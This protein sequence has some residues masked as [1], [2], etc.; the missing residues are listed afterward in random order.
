M[1]SEF[2]GPKS[3]PSAQQKKIVLLRDIQGK[4]WRD[5]APKIRNVSGEAPSRQHV[6]NTYQAFGK[7]NKTQRGGGYHR[8]GRRPWKLTKD[9]RSFVVKRLLVLRKTCVCTAVTLQRELARAKG[10][11]VDA[12]KIRK[13]LRASGFQWLPRAQKPK[14]SA[15]VM[16]RRV[17]FAE[18][19]LAMRPRQLRVR[20][21]MAMD[22]VVFGIPPADATDRENHCRVGDTHMWRKRGEGASPTLAG[23]SLYGK[24]LPACRAIGLWGGVSA[25]GFRIVLMHD[26]KKV[27]ADQWAHA[28]TGGQLSDALAAINPSRPHGPWTVLS[29]NES[30]LTAPVC[31]AAH[32]TSKVSLWKIP[33]KSPD[34][35]PVEKFWGWA[36]KKLRELDL[37]DLTAG[38]PVLGRTAY[39]RRIKNVC[40]SQAAQRVASNLAVGL[41]GV[42]RE[43]LR[44]KGAATRT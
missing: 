37:K 40:Q 26:S 4:S 16:A 43:V 15:T 41:R 1:V 44:K 42:C 23:K 21:S 39:K 32:R 38:R 34:L 31:R 35:N 22:G 28:V 7:A 14:Y 12:S 6:V 27:T 3:I 10:V 17:A 19:V 36:R 5:I 20:M 29:D 33:P 24:Q 2:V 11:S 18:E 30:F 9:A 8:C 13:V 25:D